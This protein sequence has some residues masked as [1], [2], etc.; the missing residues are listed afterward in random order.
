VVQASSASMVLLAGIAQADERGLTPPVR[1][2]AVDSWLRGKSNRC[3]LPALA[4]A[5]TP[6]S[7]ESNR[8]SLLASP[9]Y[10]TPNLR[11]SPSLRSRSG[12][13]QRGPGDTHTPPA[14]WGL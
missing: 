4:S 14:R 7:A 13:I 11:P 12:C 8:R 10:T 2:K 6:G 3:Y 5:L 9:G 1:L